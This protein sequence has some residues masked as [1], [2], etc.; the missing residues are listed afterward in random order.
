MTQS[1]EHGSACRLGIY[2]LAK[3]A[4]DR[5]GAL[6]LLAILAP[7]LAL[8]AVSVR[9]KLGRP[10]FFCQTRIGR[11]EKPFTIWKFRSMSEV[12]RPDGTYAPDEERLG[13]F[14]NWLRSWSLDE[15]PQLWNVLRGDMSFIGPRPL[16]PEYLPRYDA[17]HRNRHQV[18]PG[19]SGLAQIHGRNACTWRE[20]LNLDVEYVER[21]SLR[22]DLWITWKTLVKL[23]KREGISQPGVATMPEFRGL[24]SDG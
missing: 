16:L 21:I 3:D 5:I 4:C 2:L 22:L 9:V 11:E 17:V 12:R 10:V 7:L 1:L 13:Y 15:L 8:L 24:S 23:F 14:G 20:R 6:C 18:K 19:L